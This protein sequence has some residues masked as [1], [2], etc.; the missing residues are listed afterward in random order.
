M[1][2]NAALA[3][4]WVERG[5]VPDAIS[6]TLWMAERYPGSTITA[7]SNSASQREHIK[8]ELLR[9]GLTHGRPTPSS[10]ATA[11][12]WMSGHFFAG[13]M[14]PSDDLALWPAFNGAYGQDAELW[15][16]R[17]RLFF[18]SVAELFGYEAGRQWWVS[19]YLFEKRP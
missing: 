16:R 18:M 10:N 19:H 11:S 12:D 17:W 2:E 5:L 1:P 3:I 6:L 9:R 13:G 14:M 7:L 15:S 4:Q 8:A